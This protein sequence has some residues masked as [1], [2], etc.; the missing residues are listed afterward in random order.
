MLLRAKRPF[1][2]VQSFAQISAVHMW[3]A[4]VSSLWQKQ[5]L[6]N[7]FSL[8][9]VR[10]SL[11]SFKRLCTQ[12]STTCFSKFFPPYRAKRSPFGF[13]G[14]VQLEKL[15]FTSFLALRRRPGLGFPQT[16]FG[17]SVDVHAADLATLVPPHQRRLR[18]VF[19][20]VLTV[21]ILPFRNG[22][23]H[24]LPR[25]LTGGQNAR[26]RRLCFLW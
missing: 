11:H 26:E 14:T 7:R 9:G 23:S 4:Q 13:D 24:R 6:N 22:P 18:F 15:P 20:G 2:P 21:C 16:A 5:N 10:F 19:G 17:Q 1:Q 3:K 8:S 25:L 12:A